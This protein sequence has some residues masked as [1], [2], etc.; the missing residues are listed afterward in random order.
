[1]SVVYPG[2]Q[3]FRVIMIIIPITYQAYTAYSK[4]EL[5][6]SR[7]FTAKNRKS[8]TVVRYDVSH[9]K[10]IISSHCRINQSETSNLTVMLF[11]TTC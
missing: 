5:N 9:V 7:I 10:D 4:E 2:N 3:C 8:S 6:K 1:M 11:F